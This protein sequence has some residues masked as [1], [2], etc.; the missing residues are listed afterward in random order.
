MKLALVEAIVPYF[1]TVDKSN[2]IDSGVPILGGLLKDENHSVR[3]GT[4]QRLME[5]S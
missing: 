5:L 4:M 2:I 3:I 1:R